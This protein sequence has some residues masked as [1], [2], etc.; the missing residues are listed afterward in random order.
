MLKIGFLEPLASMNS[1]GKVVQIDDPN[2]IVKRPEDITFL[3]LCCTMDGESQDKRITT[4]N[5][6]SFQFCL[7]FPHH[8]LDV[9]TQ[10]FTL[11]STPMSKRKCGVSRSLSACF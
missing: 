2:D 1:T 10:K 3:R 4:V 6:L 8:E 5:T 7:R 9:L 11:L